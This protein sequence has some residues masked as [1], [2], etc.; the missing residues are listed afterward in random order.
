MSDTNVGTSEVTNLEI[1][2][3]MQ[4]AESFG[5]GARVMLR[6]EN[7]RLREALQAWQEWEAGFIMDNKCWGSGIA[8]FTPEQHE[9]YAVVQRLR[10]KA[11]RTKEPSN[12]E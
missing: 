11:L 1:K 5:S 2:L 10:E 8:E 6:A 7:K 9:K 3:A 12:Q 4:H